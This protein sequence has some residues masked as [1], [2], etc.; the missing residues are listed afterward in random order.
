MTGVTK[1]RTTDKIVNRFS[2]NTIMLREG[3]WHSINHW[4]SGRVV[5]G[6]WKPERAE[7]RYII[8]TAKEFEQ[9]KI[10]CSKEGISVTS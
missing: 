7:V 9:L 8:R 4:P 10:N 1:I 6:T 2:W 5:D 3:V